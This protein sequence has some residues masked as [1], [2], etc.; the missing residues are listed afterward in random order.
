MFSAARQG[1]RNELSFCVLTSVN[2]A[3]FKRARLL[4]GLCSSPSTTSPAGSSVAPEA[5]RSGGARETGFSTDENGGLARDTT[6][7]FLTTARTTFEA[8]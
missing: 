6:N 5:G 3:V 8:P 4:K 1:C 7:G 2:V